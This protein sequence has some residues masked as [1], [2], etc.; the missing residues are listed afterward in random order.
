MV[1]VEMDGRASSEQVSYV[2]QTLLREGYRTDVIKGEYKTIMGV[3]GDTSQ[4]PEGSVSML[5]GV[6]RIIRIG[7]PYKLISREY[8]RMPNGSSHD[9]IINV[10]GVKI[11]SDELTVVGGPCSVENKDRMRR[12]AEG[13]KRGGGHILRG[14]SF[15]PRSSGYSFQ[16]LEEEGLKYLALAGEEFDLPTIS[17]VRGEQQVGLV[18][19]YV[20]ILQIGARNMYNQDLIET[21]AKTGKPILFKR[22]FGA[23]IEE[24]LAF[25]DRIAQFDNKDIVLC[26]RG[27]LPVGKGREYMRYSLEVN[28]I[29]IA[30]RETTLP[31]FAD[32]SHG[33]G[34]AYLVRPAAFAAVAAG[35]HG[36]AIEVHDSPKEAMSDKDQQITPEEFKA[37]VDKC[38]EIHAMVWDESMFL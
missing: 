13:V 34:Y 4:F 3:I 32:P 17:E 10:K 9:R 37:L 27:M 31:V 19:Q 35:A 23:G 38:K 24:W 5:P 2:V 12:I 8:D 36:I 16:G 25:A 33:T 18:S 14:G 22:S 26:E 20:D 30:R 11:G 15:K 28:A 7:K 21:A 29:P 1:V 6:G